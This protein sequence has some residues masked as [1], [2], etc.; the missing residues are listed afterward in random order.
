M[1]HIYRQAGSLLIDE[2]DVAG[3]PA[4]VSRISSV[5][6]QME[7]RLGVARGG[8]KSGVRRIIDEADGISEVAEHECGSRSSFCLYRWRISWQ[9]LPSCIS[10]LAQSPRRNPYR[11]HRRGPSCQMQSLFSV[12]AYSVCGLAGCARGVAGPAI[13]RCN[14]LTPS[15]IP[16]CVPDTVL[17]VPRGSAGSCVDGYWCD[18][19]E[20]KRHVDLS[21][22][23]SDRPYALDMT[24]SLLPEPL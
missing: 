19:G 4:G 23:L 18:L 15:C 21:T 2:H 22:I 3:M 17:C 6:T 5:S 11:S 13:L 24:S 8:P 20:R 16:C 12:D 1:A 9:S 10:Y 7:H 14:H